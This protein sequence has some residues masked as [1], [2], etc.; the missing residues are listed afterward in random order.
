MAEM[1]HTILFHH[2]YYFTK[3]LFNNT[4]NFILFFNITILSIC[5]ING[6]A[7]CDKETFIIAELR[8]CFY[9]KKNVTKSYMTI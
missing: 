4:F 7:Y 8:T 1:S 9:E 2:K 3:P 5:Q 6:C